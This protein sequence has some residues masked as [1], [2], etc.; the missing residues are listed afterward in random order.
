MSTQRDGVSVDVRVQETLRLE[1]PRAGGFDLVA[2]T[3][4]H[5]S[6]KVARLRICAPDEVRIRR[7]KSREPAPAV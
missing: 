3:V 7:P 1:V 5:K 6:G 2:I 4:E